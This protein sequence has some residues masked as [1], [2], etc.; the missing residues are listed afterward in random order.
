MRNSI[1][2]VLV[3]V[4]VLGSLVCRGQSGNIYTF[5]GNGTAGF[6]GDGGLATA[7]ELNGATDVFKDA[8]GNV[9]I[10]DRGN[11]RIR[12]V[13]TAG[14]ISTIVGTGTPGY[15]GDGGP[16]LSAELHHPNGV[17]VDAAGNIYIADENNN[18]IRM[19]NTAGTIST[20]AG[21]G[22]AG[23]AGDGGPATS[24]EFNDQQSCADGQH[25]GRD[26]YVCRW[27]R[28]GLYGRRGIG[29]FC[30]LV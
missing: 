5:A 4:S 13:N 18:V 19:V 9:Y 30:E 27:R 20:I 12:K 17:A 1:Y 10:A 2:L 22:T 16:A 3:I 21:N 8:A 6:A 24:A 11:N 7:A 28:Y 14:I 25:F 26:L 23:F 15:T 29:D